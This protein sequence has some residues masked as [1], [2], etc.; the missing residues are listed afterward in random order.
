MAPDPSSGGAASAPRHL[1]TAMSSA[2]PPWPDSASLGSRGLEVAGV[3]ATELVARFATPLIVYDE[4]Q[5]RSRC[6]LA[7]SIFPRVLYA[8]KAFTSHSVISIALEEGLD[9]LASSGGEVEACSR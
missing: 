6:R 5:I 3:F 7:R 2:G 4:E 1:E 8:V 9:L